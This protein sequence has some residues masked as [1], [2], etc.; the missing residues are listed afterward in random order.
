MKYGQECVG[1]GSDVCRG[2]CFVALQ[3]AE[4]YDSLDYSGGVPG[5]WLCRTWGRKIYF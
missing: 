5:M 3:D 1:G 2:A 4:V